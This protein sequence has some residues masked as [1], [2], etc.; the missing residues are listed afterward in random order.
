MAARNSLPTPP[1]EARQ[2]CKNIVALMA[3]TIRLQQRD[4]V[5]VMVPAD[6]FKRIYLQARKGA[7]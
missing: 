6:L 7:K 2:I 3:P 5:A 1:S 4:S